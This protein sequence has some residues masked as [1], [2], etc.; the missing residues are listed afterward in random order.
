MLR[1]TL[2]L[3]LATLGAACITPSIPIPPPDPERMQFDVDL[4]LGTGTFSYPPDDNYSRAFV[5]VFN[6][7]QE[8]GVI[9]VANDD[10]SVDPTD[11]F[12]VD[13][14]DDI[15]I[16]FETDEQVVSTCVTVRDGE[17]SGVCF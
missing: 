8:E 3:A 16:S 9:T 13:S 17:P 10:G 2:V 14:G 5:Y 12:P 7:D 15:L 6:R 1:A 4:Q 11:P